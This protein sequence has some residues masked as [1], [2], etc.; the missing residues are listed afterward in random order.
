[1]EFF[2]KKWWLEEFRTGWVEKLSTVVLR[3]FDVCCRDYLKQEANGRKKGEEGRMR[4]PSLCW[5]TRIIC[6]E[7]CQYLK[8]VAARKILEETCNY[9]R[10]LHSEVDDLS[11]KLSQILA[12]VDTNTNTVD[13]KA[14]HITRIAK[15]LL[16]YSL[17]IRTRAF[18][19]QATAIPSCPGLPDT[20]PDQSSPHLPMFR[21]GSS[22]SSLSVRPPSTH[23]QQLGRLVELTQRVIEQAD[24]VLQ[25]RHGSRV[26]D[27]RDQRLRQRRDVG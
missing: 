14:R 7:R 8:K 18:T 3:G 12:S 16:M 5:G 21:Y 27:F 25:R 4:Y 9:I 26:I 1:M 2:M 24:A 10:K 17:S 19:S 22:P 11:E 13:L 6:R 20:C 23:I 15:V